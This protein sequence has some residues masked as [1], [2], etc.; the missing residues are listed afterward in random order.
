MQEDQ[1]VSFQPMGY[2][3]HTLWFENLFVIYLLY[4]LVM[5]VIRTVHLMWTLRQHRKAHEREKPL[6]SS[7][8]MVWEICYS[9]IR[10]IRNFSHLTFLLAL[11]VLSWNVINILASVYTAK[12]P[13]FTYVAAG[14]ANALVPFLM[15]IIFCSVQFS[16]AMFLE[17]LVRR[18]RLMLDRKASNS[19]PPGE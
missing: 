5:T 4:V 3:G 6:E 17:N 16:C 11:L 2:G 8:Q 14:L 18:R 10:S 19:Q 7:S 12:T 13:S 9:K 15:G 1:T